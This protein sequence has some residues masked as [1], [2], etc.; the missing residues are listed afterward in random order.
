MKRIDAMTT[1]EK[2]ERLENP[3]EQ[4]SGI[5]AGARGGVTGR[6]GVALAIPGPGATNLFTRIANARL[7]SIAT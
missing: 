5:C 7:D 3:Q 1:T 6:L 2:L 4:A